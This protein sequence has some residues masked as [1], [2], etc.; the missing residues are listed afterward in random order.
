[1]IALITLGVINPIGWTVLAG[2]V[3]ESVLT[4]LMNWTFYTNKFGFRDKTDW[5]RH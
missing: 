3:A 5:I 1:M 4:I 2:F